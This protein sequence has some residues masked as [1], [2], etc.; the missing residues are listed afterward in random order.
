MTT[1]QQR[2]TQFR[3]EV[4]RRLSCPLTEDETGWNDLS[5]SAHCCWTRYETSV[6]FRL[7]P[8]QHHSAHS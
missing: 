7:C 1:A 6:G 5:T 2:R 8:A 3:R 4:S